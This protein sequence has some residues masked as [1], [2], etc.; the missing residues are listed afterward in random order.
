MII[1]KLISGLGNQLF[2]YTLARILS[3]KHQ[4]DLKLDMSFFEKQE[5]RTFGLNNFNIYG[6]IANE[7][8][9]KKLTQ[10]F[11]SNKISKTIYT[12][13]EAK[14][15]KTFLTTYKEKK[16]FVFDANIYKLKPSFYLEGYWQ[17][18]QYYINLPDIIKN[19]L[20][21]K[22]KI[23]QNA[24]SILD[25][26]IADPVSVAIH[27]RRG[28]Y[29]TDK[30][31]NDYMGVLPLSY[32]QDAVR[33]LSVKIVSPNFYIFSDDI[34]W[35]KKHINLNNK[36]I[37]IENNKDFE[38]LELMKNCR[39]Q[40]IANSSFSWWGAFLNENIDK[41][42]IAPKTWLKEPKANNLVQIQMPNW[43]TI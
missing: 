22:V 34:E 27:I 42:V 12:N 36:T 7:K 19:E 10:K 21:L 11:Q 9:V 6:S 37:F 15:P 26:I 8:E 20:K 35:V 18:H 17:H 38:D 14:I 41:V 13:L 40:I 29:I 39:H 32:Y 23:G 25:E 4:V 24:Q 5:L 2:Q 31:A 43:I 28:D 30:A 16:W 3:L 1:V 33:L